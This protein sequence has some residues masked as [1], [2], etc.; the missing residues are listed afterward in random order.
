VCLRVGAYAHC[1]PSHRH[2]HARA[3][4]QA[5]AH[6]HIAHTH[7]A[8]THA[9]AHALWSHTT[10]LRALSRPATRARLLRPLCLPPTEPS[11]PRRTG[12]HLLLHPRHWCWCCC[13]LHTHAWAACCARMEMA[14]PRCI[15]H[16]AGRYCVARG[17]G[18][19]CVRVMMCLPPRGSLPMSLGMSLELSSSLP[20]CC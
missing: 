7:I 8:R 12:P 16:G 2:T 4:V 10:H 9:P 1:R 3:C 17:D 20:V 19:A 5:H 11:L 14:S 13:P 18:S 6:A 15:L